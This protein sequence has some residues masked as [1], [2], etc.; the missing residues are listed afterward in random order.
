MRTRLNARLRVFPILLGLSG[1]GGGLDGSSPGGSPPQ[2]EGGAAITGD[3]ATLD[4]AEEAPEDA[5]ASEWN[6]GSGSG[7]D[8]RDVATAGD[9]APFD[10]GAPDVAED[11]SGN[12][13]CAG[14]YLL[15]DDFNGSAIDLS[16]WSIGD[17]D[18]AHTYPVSP[19]N[20][21]LG[22]MSDNGVTITVV[23]AAI[24]GNL[25]AA[26]PDQGGLLITNAQYGGGRYEARMKNLP[27]PN[28]CSCMWNYYDSLNDPSPPP[29]R[30]Y[31][32]IDIEMPAHVASPPAWSTWESTLG[33]NTW[34]NSDADSDGTIIAYQSPSVNPFDGQFHVFRWDWHDGTDG[35][36]QIEWYVDGILQTSTAQHV[37]SHPAQL[38]VGNW[39]A[40]WSG[41]DYNFDVA[42]M[43]IDWVRISA[44]PGDEQ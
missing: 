21:T 42:D 41:M 27:G 30:V 43:Y 15:C 26:A 19:E 20:V 6:D 38:W 17:V 7:S 29:V 1:C 12:G 5:T 9:G 25:H 11:S 24:F 13:P 23:D 40:P 44:L 39:P 14:T 18:I 31:T 4:A 3:G 28:G 34:S 10:G 35:T 33:F 37:S 8:A 32:E 2:E 22:T 16:K 36:L